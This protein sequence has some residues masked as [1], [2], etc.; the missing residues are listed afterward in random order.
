M[1][2]AS[3]A[4]FP[5]RLSQTL[6]ALTRSVSQLSHVFHKFAA[7][8]PL[9]NFIEERGMITD[10]PVRNGYSPRQDCIKSADLGT[11]GGGRTGKIQ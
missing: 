10:K 8:Y 2:Q 4:R 5:G 11:A 6:S 3:E 9:I 1:F 7:K